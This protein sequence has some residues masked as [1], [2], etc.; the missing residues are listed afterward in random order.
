LEVD[1]L[2]RRRFVTFFDS[3]PAPQRL[4]RLSICTV[5]RILFGLLLHPNGMDSVVHF[6]MPY[7]NPGRLAKFYSEAFGWDMEQ[8]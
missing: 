4:R 6:E 1:H 3:V 2:R 5:F 8:L 7:E